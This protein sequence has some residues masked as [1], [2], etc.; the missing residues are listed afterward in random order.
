M[1]SGPRCEPV[2]LVR[3]ATGPTQRRPDAGDELRHLERLLDV[4]VGAGLEPDHD[5]DRVGPGGQHHD[6]DGRR[7]ADRPADLEA[8][9]P[10]QH[11]VEQDEVERLRREPVQAL[12]ARRRPSRP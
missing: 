8:V 4:V 7:P 6:R 11:D 12:A 1:S 5:V 10:R 2:R 9:E 3:S